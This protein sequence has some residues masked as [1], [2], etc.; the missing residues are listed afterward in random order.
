MNICGMEIKACQTIL[1]VLKDGEYV[2]LAVKKI[3]LENDE[4]QDSIRVF[5]NDML[6]FLKI[7][8]INKI[9]IKKRAKKGTFAGGAVTFKMEALIQ[10]NPHCQVELI[11][12]QKVSTYEKKNSIKYPE[13]LKKYQE[14]AYLTALCSKES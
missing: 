3:E 6:H 8:E 7:N 13:K 1:V 14:Q 12:S 4:E 10:L 2:D 5:C 9:Y 11:S